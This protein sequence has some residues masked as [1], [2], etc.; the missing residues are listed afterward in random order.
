[1][2]KGQWTINPLTE[3]L[4]RELHGFVRLRGK[5]GWSVADLDIAI[6]SLLENRVRVNGGTLGFFDGDRGMSAELVGDLAD[7]ARLGQL[8]DKPVAQILPLW[9]DINMHGGV[10]L[11]QKLFLSSPVMQQLGGDTFT[12]YLQSDPLLSLHANLLQAVLK[13]TALPALPDVGHPARGPRAAL[14]SFPTTTEFF[15]TS[16]ATL[17]LV[18]A[19]R[20]L[21]EK[22]WSASDILSAINPAG[23]RESASSS[24]GKATLS[25]D[26][27]QFF[28]SGGSNPSLLNADPKTPQTLADLVALEAYRDLRD[29]AA[30]TPASLP[31]LVESLSARPSSQTADMALRFAAATHWPEARLHQVLVAKYPDVSAEHISKRLQDLDELVS[32]GRVMEL[33][34]RKVDPAVS[35]SLLFHMGTPAA[36]GTLDPQAV[37]PSD[38]EIFDEQVK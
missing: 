8:T 6:C 25:D 22:E 16:R 12:N 14:Q 37:F 10:S 28:T 11:Y 4:C 29:S 15:T 23:T 19:W 17:D 13:V 21:L 20:G 30:R 3:T 5:C 24:T 27:R 31:A 34:L 38:V 26:E 32:L 9:G 18:E 33:L 7:A 35:V 2:A 36:P 1:M